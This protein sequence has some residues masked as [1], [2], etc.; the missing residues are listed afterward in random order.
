[1]IVVRKHVRIKYGRYFH[2]RII[3]LVLK[4]NL[5]YT[6]GTMVASAITNKTKMQIEQ[7]KKQLCKLIFLH[8]IHKTNKK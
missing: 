4:Q 7:G 1:M 2:N 3:R 8:K 5:S 6:I